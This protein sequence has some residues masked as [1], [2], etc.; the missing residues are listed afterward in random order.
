MAEKTKEFKI[1][2]RRFRFKCPYCGS[3]RSF[4]INNLRRKTVKCFNCGEP[5]KCV[6]NRRVDKRNYQAGKVVLTTQYGKEIDV[7]LR[8]ISFYG[9]GIEIPPGIPPGILTIGQEIT[10]KCSWSPYLLRSRRFVV[11]NINGQHVGVRKAT[12]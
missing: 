3:T 2:N 5:T 10:L 1:V 11:Q 9:V 6:F 4:F 7:N 8:N 12:R